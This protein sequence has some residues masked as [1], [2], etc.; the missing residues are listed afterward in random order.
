[1]SLLFRPCHSYLPKP[2]EDLA[3]QAGVGNVERGERSLFHT[4]HMS[5][6]DEAQLRAGLKA[7][8]LVAA[9]LSIL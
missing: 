9:I 5:L 6:I 3:I 8:F 1:M 7:L 2:V 4:M